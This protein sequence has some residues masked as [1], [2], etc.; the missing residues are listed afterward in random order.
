[1]IHFLIQYF[2]LYEL[3]KALY[4]RVDVLPQSVGK[5][6]GM[7]LKFEDNFDDRKLSDV[8]IIL[9]GFYRSQNYSIL[10][11]PSFGISARWVWFANICK[12]L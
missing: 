2:L 4:L 5:S 10:T 8:R 12:F 11:S 7:Q 6:V 1:M 9:P 3:S